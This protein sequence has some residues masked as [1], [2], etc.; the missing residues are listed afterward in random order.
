MQGL[1]LEPHCPADCWCHQVRADRHPAEDRIAHL[2]A[3]LRHK[4]QHR[5][6]QESSAGRFFH[7]GLLKCSMN[8]Y[9]TCTIYIQLWLSYLNCHLLCRL[10]GMWM[11]LGITLCSLTSIWPKCTPSPAMGPQHKRWAFQ[12]GCCFTSTPCLK[13]TASEPSQKFPLKC[14]CVLHVWVNPFVI[15]FL[16]CASNIWD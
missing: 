16:P 13:I 5:Q 4:N 12:S 1:L 6:H 7:A 8:Q 3:L 9:T 15:T 14:K 2:R 10:L 11:G